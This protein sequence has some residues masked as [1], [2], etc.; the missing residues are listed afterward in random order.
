MVAGRIRVNESHIFTN[1]LKLATP[2][3]RA[4]YLNEACAGRSDLRAAVEELLRARESDPDFLEPPAVSST[5]SADTPADAVRTESADRPGV[6]LAG[7]YKLLEEIGEGGMG[8]VWMAQQTEPVKRAVAVKLIK[9]GMDSKTVLARFEAERQAFALMDHPNIARVYDA[10]IAPD[11]RPFFVMELVKGVPITTYCDDHRL[12]P[13]QRLELFV[14]VCH[15]VQHAHQKGVIHRDLKPSNVLVALYDDRPV[16]KVIDFGV[17]KA[18]GQQLT[19][20]TLHTGFGAVVGTVDYMS[21][22]QATFNQ[23]DIDT[24]SDVYSLGVLLYELLTGTTPLDRRHRAETPLLELLRM[25]REEDTV[26]PSTRLS[27]IRDLPAIASSRGVEPKRLSWL[28]RGDLDWI[29]MKALEKD[30]NRRYE[31]ASGLAADLLHYLADEPVLACPPSAGYRLRKFARRNKGRL[32]VAAG[33]FLAAIVMAASVGWALRDRAAQRSQAEQA[34]IARLATVEGQVRASVDAARA[35]VDENKLVPARAKLAQARAQLGNDGPAL[36]HL[37]AVIE[38][39]EVEL[40]RFQQFQ[41]LIDHANL[42]ESSPPILERPLTVIGS[43]G[44]V[45][46][47]ANA[48]SGNRRPA[49]AIP[50]H[51]EALRRYGVLDRDDWIDNLGGGF[52]GRQQAEQIRR[53]IYEELLWLAN[54]L[55]CRERGHPS[56]QPLR[57]DEA[58][59]QA[60]GYL[61]KAEAAHRPTKALYAVRFVCRTTLGDNSSAQADANLARHTAP[62]IALDHFLR[63]QAALEAEQWV[64]A[65]KAFEAA[66]RLEPTHYWSTINLGYSLTSRDQGPPNT[67]QAIGLFTGCILKRPDHAHPHFCRAV[68]YIKARRFQEAMADISKATELAPQVAYHWYVRGLIH[69]EF[70]QPDQA[71][72]DFCRAIQLEA[73]ASALADIYFGRAKA[74]L[75]L[76]QWEKAM[77]DFSQTLTID[78][79]SVP[80]WNERGWAFT[81]LNQ[82]DKAIADFTEA[83]KRDRKMAIPWNNRGA[84]YHKQGRYQE[85]VADCTEA[86]KLDSKFAQAWNNRGAAY[87]RLNEPG[88]AVADFDQAVKLDPKFA[89]AWYNRGLAHVRLRQPAKANADFTQALT[90]EPTFALAWN[91]R[92]NTFNQLGQPEKAIA[93]FTEAIQRDRTLAMA[94]T[95]RGVTFNKLGQP[96]KA[97]DDLSTAIRLA[98]NHPPLAYAYLERARAHNRLAHFEKARTDYETFVKRAP[99]DDEGHNEL[100]WLLATCPD[101]KVRDP[102]RA[103]ELAKIAVQLAPTDG[104][105]WKTLGVAH[106][107]AGDAKAAVAALD[108]SVALN[109]GSDAVGRLFLAMSH[110][111]LGNPDEGRKVYAQAVQWLD[112]NKQA[113]DKDH[114]LAEDLRRFRAEAEDVLE[115]KKK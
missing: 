25:I 27:T 77:E 40:D 99:T 79:T 74:Y 73:K 105:C 92:G 76:R 98:P 83:I 7:R 87:N 53:L 102:N 37:A 24:R 86:L 109:K 114:W 38:N 68:A 63:G 52:L 13:R 10:G 100:A 11:G 23:L 82:H 6:V 39:G 32:A 71:V 88:K 112:E 43:P 41:E 28:V 36:P 81:E 33:V 12:T 70:D 75:K 93:D 95:N 47:L 59:R 101:A 19:E 49:A 46:P 21:P 57:P 106:Y 48:R 60:L 115:L 34:E 2:E 91:N 90:V 15:A 20:A 78:P 35:F 17:A 54:D 94:W 29:V 8:T 96:E 14:P 58:A 9:P 3:D 67:A 31:T 44:A 85:A 61:R 18:T 5:G 56:D 80:A 30:R 89:Q 66:L 111:K 110:R 69:N 64:E 55:I 113:L 72:A 50:F 1:A 84:S 45:A 51:L 104:V 22:E 4:A 65:A 97:I 16:P 107:R 108:K 103:V 26:R 42:A 62:T